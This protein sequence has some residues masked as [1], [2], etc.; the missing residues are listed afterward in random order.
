MTKKYLQDQKIL[1]NPSGELSE[2]SEKNTTF[3]KSQL[4]VGVM[5]G[6]VK[7][8]L[9]EYRIRLVRKEKNVMKCKKMFDQEI[10]AGS[11]NP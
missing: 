10:L 11:K 7:K 1:K 4:L 8:L 9:R 5:K 2:D 3:L 6:I